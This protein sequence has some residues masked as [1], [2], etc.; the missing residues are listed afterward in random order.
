MGA[1]PRYSDGG[2][3]QYHDDD[4]DGSRLKST[5]GDNYDRRV[6]LKGKYDPYNFF[7]INQNIMQVKNSR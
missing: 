6:A 2:G 7:R 3:C 1:V 4:E 5:Y